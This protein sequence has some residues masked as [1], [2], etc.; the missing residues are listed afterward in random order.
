MFSCHLSKVGRVRAS[1]YVALL[2]R[3]AVKAIQCTG[4]QNWPNSVS[5]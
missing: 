4:A 3:D 5:S 2:R 1:K